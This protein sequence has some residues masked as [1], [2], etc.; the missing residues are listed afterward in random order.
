MFDRARKVIRSNATIRKIVGHTLASSGLF[1]PYVKRFGL[2]AYWQSRMDLIIKCPDNR[3]IPRTMN[4]GKISRGKQVM[5][6]GLKINLGCYYG[7]EISKV[8]LLNKG[9]HEPQ[10]ERVFQE[11]LPHIPDGATMIEMGAFWSFYSMWFNSKIG[12]A[13]NFMIEPD[14][15][16]IISGIRNFRL[17]GMTGHFTRALIGKES[18]VLP[19]K[20]KLI[21]VDDFVKE[22]NIEYI[23]LLHSDI[24]GYEYDML[25][26]AENTFD[27]NKIGY[28]FISTHSNELHRACLDYLERK[29]FVNICS[30]DLDQTYSEDGIIVSRNRT[31]HGLDFV[32]ISKC[33]L[34]AG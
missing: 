5:H 26:G 25:L 8:L 1:D 11:V 23:D 32:D 3:F 10:E 14:E 4:A 33:E 30:A 27:S 17:N 13:R 28:V 29:K 31:I 34:D 21:C 2:S 15:Y 6:N 18:K 24:Q 22:H 19:D 7:P 20:A 9:V 12:N 16:N